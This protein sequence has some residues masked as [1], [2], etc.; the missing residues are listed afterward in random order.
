MAY[1]FIFFIIELLQFFF[2]LNKKRRNI[3]VFINTL[4]QTALCVGAIIY[5]NLGFYE[6]EVILWPLLLFAVLNF[7]SNYAIAGPFEIDDFA[8]AKSTLFDFLAVVY[9]V[10][11]VYFF[12]WKWGEAQALSES[13]DYLEAYKE[14]H[15]EHVSFHSNIF[16]QILVNYIDYFYL[17]ILLYGFCC[18]AQ[19][20]AI[21]GISVIFS[22]FLGRY[23]YATVYS[24]RTILFSL[25]FSLIICVIMFGKFFSKKSKKLIKIFGGGLILAI[26]I[27]IVSISASRFE[28]Q[29]LAEWIYAYFGRSIITFQDVVGSMKRYSDGSIFFSY[30][31]D[32]LPLDNHEPITSRDTGFNFVPEFA[33][34]YEDFGI[35]FVGFLLLPVYIIIRKHFTKKKRHFADYYLVFSYFFAIF[36]GNLYKTMDFIGMVMIVVIYQLLKFSDTKFLK[37]YKRIVIKS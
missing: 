35:W 36:I 9:V 26:V 4:F 29:E 2:F 33:R 5:L 13:G 18:L 31:V 21:Y 34:L 19:K 14:A 6:Y 11:S 28:G 17:P 37:K 1:I 7:V 15:S 3:L 10:F 27:V 25:L 12:F 16:E 30:I 20:R 32:Y 23:M 24:S 22:V 8:I